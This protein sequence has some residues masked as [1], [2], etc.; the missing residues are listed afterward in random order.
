LAAVGGHAA[1]IRNGCQSYHPIEVADCVDFV[2]AL[3]GRVA[4]RDGGP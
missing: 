3:R 4:N 2:C 1:A